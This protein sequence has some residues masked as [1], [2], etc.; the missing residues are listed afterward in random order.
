[1]KYYFQKYDE[2]CY[3]L[4]YHLDYMKENDIKEMEV[5][6]AKAEFGTGMFFCRKYGEIGETNGTCGKLCGCY[7][8][9][10]GKNGRCKFYGYTYE[11]TDKKIILKVKS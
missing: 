4:S 9:N 10:N 5:F 1:M 6:E 8:P 11:Q 2:N 3:P 7:I